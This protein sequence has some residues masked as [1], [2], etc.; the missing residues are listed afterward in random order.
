MDLEDLITSTISDAKPMI[1]AA[2]CAVVGF[3]ITASLVEAWLSKPSEEE[4]EKGRGK[5]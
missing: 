4:R 5:R 2:F 3:V 1:I